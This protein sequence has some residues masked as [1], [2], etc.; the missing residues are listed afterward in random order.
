MAEE[1][2]EY[3]VLIVK[4]GYSLA[5]HDFEKASDGGYLFTER[6]ARG[7]VSSLAPF[8]PVVVPKRNIENLVMD[9]LKEG[10]KNLNE[11]SE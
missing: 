11:K 3:Y 5:F 8:N 4:S 2:K 1:E 6:E 10:M 9:M 7:K